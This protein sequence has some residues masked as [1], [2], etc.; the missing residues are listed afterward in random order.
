MRILLAPMEGLLDFMLRDALTQS[1]TVARGAMEHC[2]V[3][4]CVSEFIR[5]TNSLLPASSFY[6]VVP[7]LK[8]HSR[9][10]SG[11]PVRLQL[12]GS[13]PVCMAANAAKAAGLG[14]AG[15]DI[16]FGCPAKIV[17]RHRGG[18][19]LLKEPELMRAIVA[20]IRAAVPASVPVT[21]KMR[22]GYEVPDYAVDCAL[23]LQDGGA[24]EITVHART[25]TDG[26]KPPAYWEWI[27]RIRAAVQVPV[28]ANGEIWTVADARRCREIS[29]CGDIMIG[30]GA[31]A[32]PALALMIRG[33][34]GNPLA[35]PDVVVLLHHYWI[36]VS[37]HISER[38]RNGRIKQWLLYLSRTYPQAQTL[39]DDIRRVIAPAEIEQRVFA[40][41]SRD[42]A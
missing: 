37:R 11:V 20:A 15:I 39:F 6:R 29:G 35:W 26:Y 19:A 5:V 32:N 14:A 23:A 30:R 25:K 36:T 4:L 27:A 10:P 3:D 38:H 31:V 18:A 34:C 40:Q 17:N 7:E 22:L 12:L 41:L 28:I 9:T 16:N 24:A 8:N 42:A 13:D 33:E 21:A 1:G 2:G